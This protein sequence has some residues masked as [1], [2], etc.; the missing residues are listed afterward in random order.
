MPA[1][2]HRNKSTQTKPGPEWLGAGDLE[3]LRRI[4]HAHGGIPQHTAAAV[5]RCIA[6]ALDALTELGLVH[7]DIKPGNIFQSALP[8]AFFTTK[9]C[10]H[11][12]PIRTSFD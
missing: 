10:D 1:L 8:A 3:D 9:G 12:T 7:C 11:K 5:L 6:A 2:E 4:Y